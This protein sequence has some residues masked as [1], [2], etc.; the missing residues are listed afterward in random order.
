M[1]IEQITAN[2]SYDWKGE[3]YSEVD[4]AAIERLLTG[5]RVTK[6]AD[7]HLLLDDGTLLKLI[8]NDGGCGCDAGCYP[9]TE[10]N[11][12]DNVIT[13]V[14][15]DARPSGDDYPNDAEG[16]YRIFVYADNERVNLATFTGS[17]GNG[18][19]GTGFEILVRRPAVTPDA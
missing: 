18:Y 2:D 16:A 10:L 19:Y 14:E 3:S 12:V 1:T 4:P 15:V 5:H 17:D 13:R 8:G 9:L 6:V 7:D 11:G